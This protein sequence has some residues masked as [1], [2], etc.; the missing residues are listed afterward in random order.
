[1]KKAFLSLFMCGIL[2]AASISFKD[3]PSDYARSNPADFFAAL[4]ELEKLSTPP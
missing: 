1:M 3:A 2:S 4:M